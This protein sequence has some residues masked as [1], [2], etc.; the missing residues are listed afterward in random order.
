MSWQPIETAP[1]DGTEILLLYEDRPYIGRYDLRETYSH[2][3]LTSRTE[4]WSG[5]RSFL[6]RDI[7][8]THWC[9]IPTI[10]A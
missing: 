7:E 3:A 5:N 9:E 1:T 8:P 10:P 4:G 2:G 6:G